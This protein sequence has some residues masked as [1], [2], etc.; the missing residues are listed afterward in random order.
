[1]LDVNKT[2]SYG[3]LDAR[4]KLVEWFASSERSDFELSSV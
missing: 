4:E 2:I 3:D 1:M